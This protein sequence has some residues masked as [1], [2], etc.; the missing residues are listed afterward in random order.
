MAQPRGNPAILS[1]LALWR[2]YRA[3]R[4]GKRQTRDTQAYE[5]KLLDNLLAAR[6]A[7]ASAS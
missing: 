2:A 6:A 5:A 7:L 3:C 4:K 1:L